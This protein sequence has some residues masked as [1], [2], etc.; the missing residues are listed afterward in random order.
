MNIQSSLKE[1]D[2]FASCHC[3]KS[4]VEF[5]RH[6]M[7]RVVFR[8]SDTGH[9]AW[10]IGSLFFFQQRWWVYAALKGAMMDIFRSGGFSE[11]SEPVLHDHYKCPLY[12]T[13]GAL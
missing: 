10:F 3:C 7:F 13:G 1:I 12:R 4:K 2:A 5:S 8:R 11:I 9:K 6:G